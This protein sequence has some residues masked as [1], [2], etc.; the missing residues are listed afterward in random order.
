MSAMFNL[1]SKQRDPL[2]LR[3]WLLDVVEGNRPPGVLGYLVLLIV[4]ITLSLSLAP[5][6]VQLL[7][8]MLIFGIAAIGLNV[9]LGYCGLVSVAQGAFVGIGA[10]TWV[11]LS[12]R[13][14]WNSL[15]A[16]LAALVGCAVL[17]FA[18]GALATRIRTHYFLIV[19]IG[20]QVVFSVVADNESGWT[21]GSNGIPVA[22]ALH[23]GSWSATSPQAILQVSVIVFIIALYI[24]NRL[25][26]S[27]QGRGMVALLQSSQAAE[28][29]GVNAPRYRALGMAIGAAYGGI[30]GA[31][32]A[33]Y[34][35]Y[36]S[37]DSFTITLS[38]ELVV[39]IVIGGI[40][41]NTGAVVGAVVL[42][43]IN[44]AT[45]AALG[46]STLILGLILMVLILIAPTGIVGLAQSALRSMLRG[47]ALP[48]NMRRPWHRANGRLRFGGR[49]LINLAKA[50]PPTDQEHAQHASSAERPLADQLEASVED[51]RDE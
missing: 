9:T 41:S 42:T 44:Q 26:R 25:R 46:L 1:R 43:W 4:L 17:G 19:T 49:S 21:G 2:V 48:V 10:Y 35:G 27:R 36:L 37:P 7:D 5:V 22:S 47:A 50:P 31:L 45:E 29:S 12:D 33:P 28:A 34:V 20:L 11:L 39:M 14:H 40:G 13:A 16:S 3:H 38:I 15:L 30:A 6:N 51:G 24:A 8:T 32:F 23:V 18:V